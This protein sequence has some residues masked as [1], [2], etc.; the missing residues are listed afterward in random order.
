MFMFAT[1]F[2]KSFKSYDFFMFLWTLW[3]MLYP[4]WW[5]EPMIKYQWMESMN[6]W[7]FHPFSLS[8]SRICVDKIF[9]LNN[10]Q[11][12]QVFRH[13]IFVNYYSKIKI[14]IKQNNNLNQIII[15]IFTLLQY[16]IHPHVEFHTWAPYGPIT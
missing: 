16:R 13:R 5:W 3:T 15:I 1:N 4:G 7:Y 12:K 10:I 8:R 11:L 9:C 14:I 2:L 6:Q